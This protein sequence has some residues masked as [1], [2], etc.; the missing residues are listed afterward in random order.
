MTATLG[1]HPTLREVLDY[2]TQESF[3]RHLLDVTRRRRVVFVISPRKHW[4]P[5]W[6]TDEVRASTEAGL[7]QWLVAQIE[8]C[9]PDV[10]LD[11]CPEF[12]P[13]FH[14]SVW[15]AAADDPAMLAGGVAANLAVHRDC[16]FEADL[17]T[18]R[19][20][21]QDVSTVIPLFEAYGA[22]YL[23]K[24]SGHRSLHIILPGDGLP[25]GFRGKA[26]S[27]AARTL[28]QWSGSRAHFLQLITRMPYS[29][30]EDSGLV[31]LPINRGALSSF[32]PWQA[33]LHV[34][35][36]PEQ[37]FDAWAT[38]QDQA[39]LESLLSDLT[40]ESPA[41][42]PT[43]VR[44][45]LTDPEGILASYRSRMAT[46]GDTGNIGEAWR[47]L[48]GS[49]TLLPGDLAAALEMEDPDA[50]W[51]M[52]EAFLFHGETLSGARFT[53]LIG[54]K[55]E[56][57]RVAATDILLRFADTIV[58][59]TIAAMRDME[60]YTTSGFV[61]AYLLT[62]SD[63]LREAVF[64]ELLADPD[65][66]RSVVLVVACLTGALI[67]DWQHAMALAEPV[68][69]LTSA[70]EHERERLAKML[71]ALDLMVTIG[72]Y[73]KRKEAAKAQA[74][75]DLGTCITDLL[76]VAV[77]S[78]S[79]WF[80]RTIVGALVDLADP[81]SI[82]LLI[83]ALDDD[84]TKVRRKALQG[85]IRIGKPAVPSL[86]EAA[87][88]DVTRIRR[89]AVQC[90]G[91][92]GAPEGKPVLIEA[93]HDAEEMVRRQAIRGLRES[94]TVDDLPVFRDFLREA[95]PRNARE[96]VE[97]LETLVEPA[98][99]MLRDLAFEERNPAAAYA[100]GA[101]G[102]PRGNEIL[103]ELMGSEELRDDAAD[104]LRELRDPRCVA[105]L[106]A[107]LRGMTDW[108]G[109][110]TAHE[111]GRIGTD[112]A[113]EGIIEAL[114]RD[115]HLIRRGAVRGLAAAGNP[116]AIEPLIAQ[117]EDPDTKTRKLVFEALVSFGSQALPAVDAA[118]AQVPDEQG[119]LR[120]LLTRL[121]DHI[122]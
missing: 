85:L 41:P 76:L 70:P 4:E 42:T 43:Q 119:R 99:A 45:E 95:T 122:A 47:R 112:E 86:I 77:G 97:A 25:R 60:T 121:R 53:S 72:T 5:N 64:T 49:E 10:A 92:I 109:S 74:L 11:E 79:P 106:V 69:D 39:A 100:I 51:L 101:Q 71:Q 98:T 35:T 66:S 52:T 15:K 1:R 61:T 102:D 8:T 3:L 88:S 81:R 78:P 87:N 27:K 22:P 75:A 63:S 48:H 108:I 29:L 37:A 32:R 114:D 38:P 96:A 14:Q 23:H 46:V 105:Y 82:D 113:V 111:L 107:K 62:Q 28:I 117:L 2:Y 16:V 56:Y 24:F 94:I 93:I 9:L 83:H 118:L 36:I 91:K 6:E 54:Q 33:N 40:S 89:Y 58:P 7:R 34:A 116:V 73:D 12:Y 65:T 59:Y 17:P 84:Y 19:D 57:V 31:C 21:F 120:A 80:R 26:A 13:A 30:N 55:E 50:R 115:S 67:G 44:L 103:V 68:R 20:A 104:F 110:H 18:W 90:L